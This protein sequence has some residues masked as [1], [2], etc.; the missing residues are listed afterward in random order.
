MKDYIVLLDVDGV[1]NSITHV[2]TNGFVQFDYHTEKVYCGPY[3][4]WVPEYIPGLLQAVNEVA[5][6]IW[7]TT[8][9]HD[10]NLYISPLLGL[11]SLSV[12]DDGSGSRYPSW[13][14]AVAKNFAGKHA[15]GTRPIY[16]IED[17]GNKFGQSSNLSERIT[18][19]D[20]D[21]YGEGVLLPQHLPTEL[22][23]AIVENGYNGPTYVG[24]PRMVGR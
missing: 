1:V 7:L 2:D 14:F 16:W 11:P 8:W 9:R 6:I 19:V 12:L 15:T 24:A 23:D 5:D 21:K 20:T 13:K 10:A 18:Y 22:L 3:P 4:I 17:F